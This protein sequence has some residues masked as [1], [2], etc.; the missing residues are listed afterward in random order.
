MFG[1]PVAGIGAPNTSGHLFQGD[2]VTAL[3]TL[4]EKGARYSQWIV[5]LQA[6]PPKREKSPPEPVGANVFYTSLGN[7]IE[8]VSQWSSVSVRTLGPFV[9][10]EAQ[11]KPPKTRDKRAGFL[12]DEAHLNLGLDGA[13]AA[14]IRLIRAKAEIFGLSSK[15]FSDAEVQR[16]RASASAV[17]LTLEEERAVVGVV[18]ALLSY[19]NVIQHAEGLEDLLYKVV[20][21]PSL[22]SVLKQGGVSADLA[23]KPEAIEAIDGVSWGLPEGQPT[24]QFPLALTI[25]R[26]LA[27]EIVLIV[28][29]P[30]SPLLACGG[31]VG[32]VATKPSAPG[33]CLSLKIVNA[34]SSGSFP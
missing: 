25:N 19:M 5:Y 1:I 7:K 21:K 11:K 29:S 23:V 18:P 3:V 2:S 22:W 10:E 14:L 27:L 16:S 26:R 17:Q 20:D 4:C 9:E 33:T 30:Q 28:T 13:A 12:V 32:L 15:P 34:R 31:I 6:E 24:Y 8:F